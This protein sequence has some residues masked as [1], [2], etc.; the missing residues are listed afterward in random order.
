MEGGISDPGERGKDAACR[1]EA[2]AYRHWEGRQDS[3]K[4]R[5]AYGSYS[6]EAVEKHIAAEKITVTTGGLRK[7]Q[8]EWLKLLNRAEADFTEMNEL[9][10]SL[11]QF[12]AGKPVEAVKRNGFKR[13]ESGMSALKQLKEQVEKLGEIDT[14]YHKAERGS[15][16]VIT[17]N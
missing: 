5:D 7:K 15:R 2:G 6:K 13:Q 16:N 14:I 3:G 8:E 17:D 12:F 11:E 4:Y 9:L 1:D 10:S